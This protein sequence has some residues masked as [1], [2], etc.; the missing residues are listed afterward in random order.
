VGLNAL[1]FQIL[2]GPAGCHAA[3]AEM[4][5]DLVQAVGTGL[6]RHRHGLIV[7]LVA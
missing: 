4:L 6:V 2:H 5:G 7:L 3:G 1:A